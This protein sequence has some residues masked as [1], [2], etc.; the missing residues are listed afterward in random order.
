MK[1]PA[2]PACSVSQAS[3][4]DLAVVAAVDPSIVE[5][6]LTVDSFRQRLQSQCEI[7][8]GA[9]IEVHRQIGCA[10]ERQEDND[11]HRYRGSQIW[12]HLCTLL[13]AVLTS[14]P[15]VPYLTSGEGSLN[16]N[17]QVVR[18]P[19]NARR[20]E[21]RQKWGSGFGIDAFAGRTR[22]ASDVASGPWSRARQH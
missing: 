22:S 4:R 16:P 8:F 19:Y 18:A 21:S 12:V 10:C 14:L 11:A 9:A 3:Y 7:F 15:T 20:A 6:D 13:L 1:Q 2:E 17:E 5:I